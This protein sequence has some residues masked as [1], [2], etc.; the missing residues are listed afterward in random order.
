MTVGHWF[1]AAL[2]GRQTE[3]LGRSKGKGK[4][5]ANDVKEKRA[6]GNADLNI[7]RHYYNETEEEH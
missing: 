6:G 2:S 3:R 7:N 1:L 4:M 5:E